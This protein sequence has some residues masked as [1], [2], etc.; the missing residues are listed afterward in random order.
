MALVDPHHHRPVP[1]GVVGGVLQLGGD[2]ALGDLAVE[3]RNEALDVTGEDLVV[4][5]TAQ[6]YDALRPGVV[7][8]RAAVAEGNAQLPALD[9]GIETV[10]HGENG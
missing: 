10:T 6:G 7:A 4:V 5:G 9:A 2:A 1:D 8:E 3:V